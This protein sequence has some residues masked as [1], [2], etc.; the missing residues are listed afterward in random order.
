M[1]AEVDDQ[2]G[3]LFADLK[4]RG[5]WDD[6]LIVF[7]SDH[8]EELGDHW[9]TGKLGF[10]DGSYHVPLIVRDPRPTADAERGS[11]V[12]VFSE[13]IDVMPTMLDWL[14]MESLPTQ[15]DGRSLLPVLGGTTPP[16]WREEVR[17]E[18]D[19][20]IPQITPHPMG[21]RMDQ[22]QLAVVRTAD[23][24]YVH[25]PSLP[26][27]YYDLSTDPDETTDLSADPTRTRQV[28]EAAQRM[29]TWR[30][31]HAGRGLSGQMLTGQ[32]V[33][34]GNDWPR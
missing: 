24:K 13:N 33:F 18:F 26:P 16:D 8:G 19:F 4:R 2:L 21:M 20:R 17:W 22:A 11:A 5:L 25:F 1:M 7:T 14:G 9:L 3:R 34:E 10:F 29:L 31:E 23:A 27:L 15:C 28:L 32:G 30:Q 12:E 6:T